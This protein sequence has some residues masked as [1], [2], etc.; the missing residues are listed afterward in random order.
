MKRIHV[1]TTLLTVSMALAAVFPRST[2]QTP[3]GGNPLPPVPFGMPP[4][5]LW[6]GGK[7]QPEL[8]HNT[9][10]IKEITLLTEQRKV[11][12]NWR[13]AQSPTPDSLLAETVQEFA[14]TYWP[15]DVCILDAD[16]IYVAGKGAQGHTLIERWEFSGGGAVALPVGAVDPQTGQMV[17]T[18]DLPVRTAVA[19]VL[20]TTNAANDTVRVM[21]KN[22]ALAN[23]LFV[24]FHSTRD[25]YSLNTATGALTL[26]LGVSSG[27]NPEPN[28]ATAYDMY[29]SADHTTFGYVYVFQRITL[30][31][32][33]TVKVPALVLQDTNRDG[34]IDAHFTVDT[35]TWTNPASGWSDTANY[36]TQF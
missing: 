20:D 18:W 31:P 4:R 13:Y 35:A 16:T 12:F 5:T 7:G 19:T 17:Y 24:Q 36:T 3:T 33:Q 32:G 14:L 29:W 34:R 15:T 22:P 28:L 1:I 11:V 9:N 25:L 10:I 21:F 30:L 6:G 2:A 27:T 26:V 8:R 23:R